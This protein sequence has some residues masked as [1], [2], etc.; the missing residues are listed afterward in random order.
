LKNLDLM[1]ELGLYLRE[2]EPS[3]RLP[4]RVSG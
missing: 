1:A 4:K 3:K 2:L